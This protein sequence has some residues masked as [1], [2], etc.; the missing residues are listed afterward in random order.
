MP[1]ALLAGAC[2]GDAEVGQ[3]RPVGAAEQYVGGLDVLVDETL[4]VRFLQ[5]RRQLRGELGSQRQVHWAVEVADVLGQRAAAHVAHG[6]VQQLILGR[7]VVDL[8]DVRMVELGDA[9]RLGLEL[10]AKGSFRGEGGCEH[11]DGYQRV[12]RG[13]L[14]GPHG[15]HATLGEQLDELVLATLQGAASQI[16][17]HGDSGSG[18]RPVTMVCPSRLSGLRARFGRH[19]RGVLI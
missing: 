15:G 13:H 8:D 10:L 16:G 5:R 19:D 3:Q 12:E 17:G 14:G 6:D 18:R 2:P 11:F 7:A 9:V 1:T 4:V